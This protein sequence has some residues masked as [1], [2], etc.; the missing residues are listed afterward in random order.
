M[1]A[2]FTSCDPLPLLHQ[3]CWSVSGLTPARTCDSEN[4]RPCSTAN[5]PPRNF[6][7]C[8]L[9]TAATNKP[10]PPSKTRHCQSKASPFLNH[11]PH[12]GHHG[13]SASTSLLARGLEASVRTRLGPGDAAREY[14]SMMPPPQ[15]VSRLCQPPPG[16]ALPP[17]QPRLSPQSHPQNPNP[18]H[19]AEK[20]K[21]W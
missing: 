13:D 9:R 20:G 10:A 7:C 15:P 4:S 2:G 21:T 14:S 1:A 6:L 8:P 16:R 3:A 18:L 19:P 12:P 17:A 11:A 5:A